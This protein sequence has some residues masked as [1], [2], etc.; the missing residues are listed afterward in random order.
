MQKHQSDYER[1]LERMSEWVKQSVEQDVLTLMQ[2]EE[3]ARAYLKAAED[4]SKDEIHMLENTL[5]R[6]LQ[7]FAHHWQR[8]AE[9]SPW[10]QAT[11]DKF[12]SVLA[13]LSDKSRLAMTE[14]WRDIRH[15]G[16]YQ[17]GEAVALGELECTRCHN[18]HQV[19]HA[20]VIQPCLECGNKRFSRVL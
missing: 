19:T 13:D 15:Q 12:W 20:E 2:I 14:S 7:T 9:N 1:L 8:D 11:K 5:T 16:I 17:A 3:Q 10:W 4:L 18:R 6:D